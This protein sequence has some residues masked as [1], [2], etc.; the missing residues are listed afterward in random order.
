[1][2]RKNFIIRLRSWEYWPF[3]I[4][5]IPIFFY[6]VWLSIRARSLFFFSA[7]NPGIENG[8]MLGESKIKIL[9]KLDDEL[10]PVTFLVRTGEGL[11][12]ISKKLQKA[13]LDYPIIAK[14]DI[15]ER[16]WMVEKIVDEA[17]LSD[18]LQRSKVDFLIQEYIDLP[19]EAGVFYYRFP[20]QSQGKV[21]SIV[22]KEMLH[23]RG[24]GHSTL[25]DLI[26]KNDRA[27]L[28]MEVLSEVYDMSEVLEKGQHLQLVDIGNHCKGTKFLNGNHLINDKMHL[29]FDKISNGV[30]GFY[31]GRYDL[32]CASTDDMYQGKVKIMELNGA[33][34]EP[35]HIY[36]PGF[37]ILTAYKVLF[38]HWKTLFK[39]SRA[40]HR[41]GIPYL[42]L[43]EGWKEYQKVRN[44]N[45]TKA[46][47]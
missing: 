5:Y 47:A 16:G 38:Q 46:T 43:R 22:L 18:Y 34:A 33:G 27:K 3:G 19:V 30:Q 2:G 45:K 36:Q 31:Y 21:S 32:R 15:G 25:K 44:Y 10:K 37:S 39:I 1:M 35:A 26:L 23:V 29:A 20:G 11:S 8:G 41:L 7:S 28:Q 24:D 40:N 9:D 6:W 12:S 17:N 4:V 14:P 13:N 42:S